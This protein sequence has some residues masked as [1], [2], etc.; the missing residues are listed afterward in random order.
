MINMT[1]RIYLAIERAAYAHRSQKR[2]GSDV[3]YIIHPFG[4]MLI[5]NKATND[6]DTL[7]A[8]M[9]HDIIEDVPEEY[10]REQ[11][12]ADFGEK[13]VAI[14]EGVTKDSSLPT[15][16]ARADGY[17]RNLEHNAPPESVIVCVA[18]KIH[19]LTSVLRDY[20][21]VGDEVWN[22]FKSDKENNLWWYRTVLELTTKLQQEL[23]INVDLQKLVEKFEKIKSV[24]K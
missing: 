11:M 22:K 8:C 23:A 9:L 16:Q 3:P 20:E 21:A 18:D 19:N 10:S 13:V 1:P 7:I 6:E 4:V 14:V 15:W 12:L 2:K 5:A 24:D 17:L